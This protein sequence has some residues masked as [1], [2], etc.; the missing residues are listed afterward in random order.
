MSSVSEIIKALQDSP[1]WALDAERRSLSILHWRAK[2]RTSSPK[3]STKCRG[4]SGKSWRAIINRGIAAVKSSN[5]LAARV[6]LINAIKLNE[7]SELAWLWLSGAVETNEERK[8]C[9]EK[10]LKIN[11]GSEVAKRGLVTLHDVPAVSPIIGTQEEEILTLSKPNKVHKLN[12]GRHL[13]ITW[14]QPRIGDDRYYS[15]YISRWRG[16]VFK[17]HNMWN[18][19]IVSHDMERIISPT[20]YN[21][22]ENAKIW[23]NKRLLGEGVVKYRSTDKIITPVKKVKWRILPPGKHPFQEI[24][25]HF[26]SFQLEGRDVRIDEERLRLVNSLGATTI[27]IGTDEFRRYAIFYFDHLKKAVLECPIYGNAIYVINGDWESLSQRTK[28]ELLKDYPESVTRIT[29]KTNW[30]D[31]LKEELNRSSSGMIIRRLRNGKYIT[32]NSKNE[33]MGEPRDEP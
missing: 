21:T 7:T 11:P 10:V 29:H 33:A 25:T 4:Y 31:I 23:C 1:E 20:K 9:M 22:S 2:F 16:V 3:A 12:Y 18:A 30:F 32:L 8:Y 14:N 17:Q 5:L 24:L 15:I 6:F 27:Y 28:A 19:Y 13:V 26:K